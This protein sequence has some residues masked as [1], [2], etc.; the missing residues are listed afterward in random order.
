MGGGKSGYEEI[1]LIDFGMTRVLK[2][3]VEET[4]MCGTPE[5]VGEEILIFVNFFYMENLVCHIAVILTVDAAWKVSEFGVFSGLYLL[6]CGLNSEIHSVSLFIQFEF[7]EK[8][9]EKIQ[10]RT[11]FAQWDFCKKYFSKVSKLM[12]KC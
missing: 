5:F 10:I 3:G 2:E 1:K 12:F 4:A 6:V 9:P 8:G 11:L 7:G